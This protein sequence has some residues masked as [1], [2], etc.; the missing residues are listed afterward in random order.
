MRGAAEK[1]T[2]L[3]LFSF[4]LMRSQHLCVLCSSCSQ[5]IVA[6]T[7]MRILLLSK[8]STQFTS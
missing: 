1:A 4:L 8:R 5:R 6:L 2:T 7:K 3:H